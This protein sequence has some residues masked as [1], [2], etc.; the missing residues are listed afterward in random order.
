MVTYLHG[1][2]T[3]RDLKYWAVE[4]LSSSLDDKNTARRTEFAFRLY[5]YN[6]IALQ[7]SIWYIYVI[8]VCVRVFMFVC[9]SV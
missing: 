8:S 1:T 3:V 9:V 6:D 5:S 7:R 4:K 2:H